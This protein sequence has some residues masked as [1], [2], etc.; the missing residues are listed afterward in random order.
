MGNAVA[1]SDDRILAVRCSRERLTVE[2]A[3]GRKLSVPLRWY[4]RLH[5]ATPA[6]RAH[7]VPCAAG[8]GIHWPDI[9]EDLSI[10]GLLAEKKYHP[11]LS[12]LGECS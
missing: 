10:A 11:D 12:P 1:G 6:Q 7:W 9:D 5:A 3:D 4:P 2:L 8:R